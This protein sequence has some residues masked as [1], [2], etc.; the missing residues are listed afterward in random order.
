MTVFA[1]CICNTNRD[2]LPVDQYAAFVATHPDACSAGQQYAIDL[3]TRMLF[4]TLRQMNMTA[5][6]DGYTSGD[7]Y[8][9]DNGQTPE[10]L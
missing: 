4:K 5:V 6:I 7:G 3:H 2:R 9:I 10:T 1:E 8:W